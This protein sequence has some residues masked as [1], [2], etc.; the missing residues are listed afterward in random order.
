MNRSVFHSFFVI[1]FLLT[2]PGCSGSDKHNTTITESNTITKIYDYLAPEDY[3]TDTLI[4]FDIDNTLATTPTDL[5]SDQWFT[6]LIHQKITEGHSAAEAL[7]KSL[8]PYYYVQHHQW[9][10]PIEPET[11]ST[12]K[13][14][15]NK[16]ITVIALTSRGLYLLYR[17]LEQ[18]QRLDIDFAKTGPPASIAPFGIHSP[19][20]YINGIIFVSMHD[21]GAVLAHW[22]TQLNFHPHKIV[23]IDDKLKN[24]QSVEQAIK[25]ADYPFIGIRYARLDQRVKMFDMHKT[26]Q[27]YQHLLQHNPNDKPVPVMY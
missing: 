18:L 21:K 14:L 16:G 20:L 8:A 9:L 4:V 3:R 2:L 25:K 15:Q 12:I 13:T 24:I 1:F 22:L 6:A 17:T 27:E 11:V 10:V 19:A 7:Q 23:F 5:G 26:E